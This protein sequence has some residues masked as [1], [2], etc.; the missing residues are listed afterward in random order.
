MFGLVMCFFIF[1]RFASVFLWCS[2]LVLFVIDMSCGSWSCC[3]LSCS[4]G[5][6][7]R[8]FEYVVRCIFLIAEALSF[9]IFMVGCVL[10]CTVFFVFS[11]LWYLCF[12]D[13]YV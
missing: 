12:R 8:T 9:C 11:C 4:V 10:F 7:V 13:V 3:L 1:K 6:S 5:E 2:Y